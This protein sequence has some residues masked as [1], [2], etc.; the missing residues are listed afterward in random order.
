[1]EYYEVKDVSES[2]EI[3]AAFDYAVENNIQ[4][5]RA[6]SKTNAIYGWDCKATIG[7]PN[8]QHIKALP[9]QEWFENPY[10]Q[11]PE[12]VIEEA[13][14]EIN[15]VIDET[16]ENVEEVTEKIDYEALYKEKCAEFD[17]LKKD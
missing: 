10:Y 4:Y 7:K 8:G 13:V 16:I 2:K 17:S 15:D 1:M 12:E 11:E 3:K 5:Y 9:E 6:I 14:E